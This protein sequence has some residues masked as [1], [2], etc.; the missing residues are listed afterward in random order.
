MACALIAAGGTGTR[1]GA[2][3][4]K[5]YLPLA[6]APILARTLQVFDRCAAISRLVLVVPEED[7][8]FC[9]ESI[10]APAGLSKGISV[11]AGGDTR[12]E[13]VWRGLAQAGGD[14]DI[15]AIHD[16]VRPIVTPAAVGACVEAARRHGASVLGVPA[17]D[18]LKQATSSG[19]VVGTLPREGVWL[20]QTPQAF[21]VGL[22]R[23]AHAKAR[24]E[25][26]LGTDDAALV[27]RMGL[28]VHLV[29]G[30]RLNIKITTPEDLKIAEVFFEL[31][32]SGSSSAP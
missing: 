21:R 27:E 25:G 6:G 16:A 18:T 31:E 9:R 32:R 1:F 3:R 15:V 4:P 26:Y 28:P 30:S 23:A 12:Q 19:S 17:W 29:A 10:V 7:I 20:A 2:P 5:Q 11:A 8:A 24:A 22:I 13:S 14:E